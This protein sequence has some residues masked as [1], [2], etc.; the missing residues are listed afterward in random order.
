MVVAHPDDETIF[1][2]AA[3]IRHSGWHVVCLT[4]GGHPRRRRELASAM[5]GAGASWTIWDYPDRPGLSRDP[6]LAREAWQP[7]RGEIETRLAD[8]IEQGGYDV[9]ATHGQAGEYGHAHHSLTHEMMVRVAGADRLS[10]F[11]LGR[12]DHPAHILAAK[13]ALIACYAAQISPGEA[14]RLRD[15]ITRG[16]LLAPGEAAIRL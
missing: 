3:L 11:A 8:L 2:G 16:T 4:N 14:Y 1:G 10:V 7:W 5:S 9:V 6:V 13:R 15:W 12:D